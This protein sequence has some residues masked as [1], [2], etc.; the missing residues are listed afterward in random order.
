MEALHLVRSIF[1]PSERRTCHNRRGRG[2]RKVVHKMRT[3]IIISS[4]RGVAIST[5]ILAVLTYSAS[6]APLIASSGDTRAAVKITTSENVDNYQFELVNR[7]VSTVF[8]SDGNVTTRQE[9][10]DPDTSGRDANANRVGVLTAPTVTPSSAIVSALVNR[11]PAPQANLTVTSDGG[12]LAA[13]SSA[14]RPKSKFRK[15]I[16][17]AAI[18]PIAAFG[19]VYKSR[20]PAA[21]PSR[22]AKTAEVALTPRPIA[23]ITMG[24][25][26]S[27]TEKPAYPANHPW[28]A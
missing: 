19:L 25:L 4:L 20:R 24:R 28:Y 15:L 26:D 11:A 17:A 14:P 10:A 3:E 2:F 27:R 13:G 12:D 9:S 18:L 8:S 7:G 22:K 1:H 23:G 21:T 5:T 6:G 16:F